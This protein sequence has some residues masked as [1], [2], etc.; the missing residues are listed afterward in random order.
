MQT[1]VNTASHRRSTKVRY[2]LAHFR[3]DLFFCL[4]RNRLLVLAIIDGSDLLRKAKV[5]KRN[6]EK[7]LLRRRLF[8]YYRPQDLPS[9]LPLPSA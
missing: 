8:F 6:R 5:L 4:W 9:P 7:Q 3:V 2:I 1:L